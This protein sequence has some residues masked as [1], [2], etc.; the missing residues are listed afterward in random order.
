MLY[1]VDD[2]RMDY[3]PRGRR[4]AFDYWRSRMTPNDFEAICAALEVR[5][6][7]DEVHTSSWIPGSDWTGTPYQPIYEDACGRDPEAAA[8][9][10]GLI[11]WYV[12]ATRHPGIWGFGH[13]EK[14]GVSIQGMTYFRRN[15]PPGV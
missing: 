8:K 7:T 1:S 15:A 14:D 11:V 4:K 2:K 3:V 12:A 6:N 13:F 9:F 10:F 5:F